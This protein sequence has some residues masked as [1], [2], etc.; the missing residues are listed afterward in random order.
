MAKG[1]IEDVVRVDE[2][3]GGAAAADALVADERAARRRSALEDVVEDGGVRRVQGPRSSE[4]YASR[5]SGWTFTSSG[6][7]R[8]IQA[9]ASEVRLEP[10]DSIQDSFRSKLS[11]KSSIRVVLRMPFAGLRD[12]QRL[13][14]TIRPPAQDRQRRAVHVLAERGYL[15]RRERQQEARGQAR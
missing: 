12:L 10:Q 8:W 1:R 3:V 7:S 14:R 4:R 15:L 6:R 5:L 11:P 9:N 2:P 13:D